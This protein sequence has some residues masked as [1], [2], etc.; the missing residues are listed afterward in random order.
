ML[1]DVNAELYEANQDDRYRIFVNQGGTSS[2]K[3]Y[4]IMQLLIEISIR[5]P[6]S[7]ITVCGQDLPNLK[8]GALRDMETIVSAS[9]FLSD[10]FQE[11]K[12]DHYFRGA[13]ESII[14]FKSYS[15]PQDAKNGKRDYLFV[16]EANGIT[17][18][19]F[20]QLQ[21]RTR[22]KV[23]L[24]Y[25]PTARFWV[26]DQLI[27]RSDTKLIISDHR[28][29]RFLTKGEHEKIEGIKDR[30]LWMVYAR[31]LTGKISGL[32][33]MNWDIVDEL[34]PLEDC[35][36][37]SYG[38][39]FGFSVDPTALEEVRLA[40][41]E[42][43]INELIY[44]PGM[45]NIDIANRM[46]AIG[47]NRHNPVIAD[48]AEPKS[49]EEIRRLGHYII[50]SKKGADSIKNGL[51]ILRRYT[52]HVTRRSHGII[53]NLKRYKYKVDKDGNK[54]NE[55]IDEFNHGI[56]AI[57]YVALKKLAI[58]GTGKARAHKIELY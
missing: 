13:N 25:N 17:F 44:E 1:F 5:E 4:C 36:F 43:W 47:I 6:R 32:V 27:G 30:E 53:D 16:N 54:T 10:W 35:K 42:L 11:N 57:R 56:D 49:I 37:Q 51:D 39:D 55:P 46:T 40:H 58:R 20:W 31:G 7:V 24:D 48:C 2:G 26:H 34:P 21:I 22:K 19:I 18:E 15:T 9:E 8:V 12:S 14:E 3:T 23:F 28:G 33:F 41:G 50:P 52:M 29:N 38:L 45:T